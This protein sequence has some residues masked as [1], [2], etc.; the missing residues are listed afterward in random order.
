MKSNIVDLYFSIFSLQITSF[1][2]ISP[3]ILVFI[4]LINK[5]HT[6]HHTRKLL[7]NWYIILYFLISSAI[8]LFSGLG[9]F[10]LSIGKFNFFPSYNF[11]IK[12]LVTNSNF[13][14]A[15]I[16]FFIIGF[17][18]LMLFIV[19]VIKE[20]DSG[21]YTKKYLNSVKINDLVLYLYKNYGSSIYISPYPN[22]LDKIIKPNRSKKKEKKLK[23][24][25]KK[26]QKS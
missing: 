14:I 17:I 11:K 26:K 24:N 5:E 19:Q 7:K 15:V 13:S 8:V 3:I 18:P 25:I 23:R 2:I 4:Q 10:A 20:L 22:P 12:L 1:S 16:S 6:Y 9:A 21:F